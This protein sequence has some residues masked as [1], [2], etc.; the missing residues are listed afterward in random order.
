VIEDDEL[1]G[2]LEAGAL[3]QAR[4]FSWEATADATLGVYERARSFMRETALS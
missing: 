3:D 4:E 2:R 1:R